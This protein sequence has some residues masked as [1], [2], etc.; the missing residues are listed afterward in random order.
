ME[1]VEAAREQHNTNSL[2]HRLSTYSLKT[3]VH[4]KS[5]VS[6]IPSIPAIPVEPS[7]QSVEEMCRRGDIR[8]LTLSDD[9]AFDSIALPACIQLTAKYIY[10]R[11]MFYGRF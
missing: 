3:K 1:S 7:A 2:R 6:S 9:L 8:V 11:G 10:Q 4:G 5:N